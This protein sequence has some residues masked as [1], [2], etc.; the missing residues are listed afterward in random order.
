MATAR[1]KSPRP[2]ITKTE[3]EESIWDKLGTLGR[4]KR[5]KEGKSPSEEP[6]SAWP[7]MV[8]LLNLVGVSIF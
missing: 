7:Y 2:I 5:I 8:M 1:P 4:K 3:K 6:T